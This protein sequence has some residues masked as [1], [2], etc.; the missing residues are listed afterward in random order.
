MQERF[1]NMHKL[2]LT[3]RE[4]YFLPSP[5]ARFSN[6]CQQTSAASLW[7]PWEEHARKMIFKKKQDYEKL[8]MNDD[9]LTCQPMVR[10]MLL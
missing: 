10:K 7:R 9:L 5:F 3:S 4:G 2:F 6:H 8:M 1:Q